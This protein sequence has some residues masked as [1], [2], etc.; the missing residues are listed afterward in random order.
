MIL[1]VVLAVLTALVLVPVVLAWRFAL[2][3]PPRAAPAPAEADWPH[4]AVLLCLRG[5]DPALPAC[6]GALVELDYPSYEVVIIVD[7]LDD[8]A[9][10]VLQDALGA[11]DRPRVRVRVE[12]LHR[13]L[14]TC[15]LKLSAQ[16][17]A[18]DGLD[19]R[20][21]VVALIDA[22]VVPDRGWLRALVAPFRD[23]RVGASTGFRWYTPQDTRWGTLVR[24]WWNFASVCHMIAFGVPWGG[25]LAWHLGRVGRDRLRRQLAHSFSED[26]ST[27]PLLRALGQRLAMVPEATMVCPET[28]DLPRCVAFIRRQLLCVRLHHPHWNA[29]VLLSAAWGAALAATVAL[30][31]L[32]PLCGLAVWAA[33]P[34]ALLLVFPL[35]A[36][37]ALGR[38]ERHLRQRA[39]RRGEPFRGLPLSWRALPTLALTAAINVACL[40][41]AHCLRH[42]SWRG[43]DYD[44]DPDG[45]VHRGPYRP[46]LGAGRGAERGMSVH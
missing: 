20:C 6:L 13:P 27:A 46:F 29:I 35:A 22:D 8:P 14:E 16:V 28:I 36:L 21:R 34:A 26:T 38:V 39:R 37:T 45:T 43:I 25:S 3:F 23:E 17:Q 32:L 19:G 40:V 18:L 12:V 11:R 30:V 41:S 10:Q 42:V 33:W 7:D 2:L 9:W 31:G 24:Y 4:A 1:A 15:S 5:A 44:I